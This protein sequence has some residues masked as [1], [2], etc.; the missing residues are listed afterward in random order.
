M[1]VKDAHEYL[2]EATS[3]SNL[4]SFLLFGGEPMLY[5]ASAVAIF[6]KAEELKIPKIGMLTNGFWG[7]NR[8]EAEKLAKKLKV[9][10]LNTLGISIDAFHLAHIPLQYARNAGQAS[11]KAGIEQVTWNV[12]VLESIDGTNHY[13]ML[14]KHLLKELEPDRIEPHIHQVV[15]VGRAVHNIPQYFKHSPLDGP[16]QGEE[17]IG[18][19]LTDPKSICIEPSG[20]VD[21]C[22]HLSVG[23]AKKKPLRRI[24]EGYDW[25]QDETTR[26]LVKEGPM[27]LLKVFGTN[28]LQFDRNKYINKCHLCIEI[29]KALNQ[30]S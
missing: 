5:P 2:T 27:G 11:V 14:T 12:A 10:G 23:N 13:D 16:C 22:W 9:A 18:N 7:K 25:Q 15:A 17:P 3:V 24:L 8:R 29:R 26:T 19:V 28:N 30:D 20:S 6:K 21:I 1:E 4:E